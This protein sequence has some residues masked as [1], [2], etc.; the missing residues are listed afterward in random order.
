MNITRR[1]YKRLRAARI[2][3]SLA[4][5]ATVGTAC[6]LGYSSFMS[7]WQI[8]PALLACSLTWLLAW[9]AVTLLLGRVYCS[10]ACPMGTLQDCL[11][12]LSRRRRRGFSFMPEAPALRRSVALIAIACPLAGVSLVLS[13]LDPAAAFSRIAVYLGG[14]ALRPAMFSIGGAAVALATL[15]LVAAVALTRGRRLCNTLC[16]VGTVLGELSRFSLYHIDIDTDK[17][18]GCNR[19]VER[20]KAECIDPSDH[21]VDPSRCVVCFDCTAACP[22]GAITL[23]RGRHRLS[24]PLMQTAAPGA[25]AFDAPASGPSPSP[26]PIDRRTFIAAALGVGAFRA[27]A[28]DGTGRPLNAVIPPGALS[29]ADFL[30]RCTGCGICVAACPA[31]IIRPAARDLKLR[32]SLHP[33]LD[34][35]RGACRFDCV[36]CTE[37][38]PT[39]ALMPIS[40][41]KKHILPIGK[42]RLVADR[43]VEFA[44]GEL[45]GRCARRCPV[46]AI[47]F[48]TATAATDGRP[49]RLP[50]VRFDSCIGCG[51][52]RA[53]CP[54]SPAAWI[55]EGE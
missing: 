3:I 13:L 20:C 44:D 16:P 25:S 15:V 49:R 26:R 4:V 28:A 9:T 5:M 37:V 43:C 51:E 47:S 53:A 39:G 8:V 12:A 27:M 18:T 31:G 34:F 11:I 24:M 17:C 38:C 50:A 48:V 23:R 6:A 45:C 36:R 55:I 40:L 30:G 10:S 29:R 19:C 41:R 2:V 1:G 35:D 33:V 32:H 46:G 52:C 7:R 54:S 21:T 22:D 42:A 14:A